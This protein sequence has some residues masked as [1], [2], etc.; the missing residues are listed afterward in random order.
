MSKRGPVSFSLIVLVLAVA[1]PREARAQNSGMIDPA[2]IRFITP[3]AS[4]SACVGK[5]TTPMC[6]VE[7][8]IGC[9]HYIWNEECGYDDLPVYSYLR[10]DNDRVEYVI[11]NAGL[12]N[13]EKV[14]IV[15]PDERINDPGFYLFLMKGAFQAKIIDR[16]CPATA[17]SCDGAP[18]EFALYSVGPDRTR[19]GLWIGDGRA[20]SLGLWFLD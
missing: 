3:T 1:V 18:W 15:P 10:Q 4:S 19:P 16:T 9:S 20:Y 17:A 12:V 11:L 13:P 6:A 5:P 7:T 2:E 8:L 14:R